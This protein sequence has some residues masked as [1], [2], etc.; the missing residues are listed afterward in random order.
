MGDST[1][2]ATERRQAFLLN[3]A[4]LQLDLL[5][6]VL[7]GAFIIE[8]STCRII[9]QPCRLRDPNALSGFVAINL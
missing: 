5:S 9:H 3:E 1:S 8:G 7:D 6:N 2:D 4:F